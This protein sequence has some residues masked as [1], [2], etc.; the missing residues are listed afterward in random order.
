VWEIPSESASRVG[1]PAPFPVE[2]PARLIHLNT[3]VGDVVLDPFMGS[4]TTAIAALRTGRH[5]L[6][7]EMDPTYVALAEERVALE[8]QRRDESVPITIATQGRSA[9]EIARE[10]IADAGF[11]DIAADRKFREGVDVSFSAR[12]AGGAEFL[13][14]VAGGFTTNYTGLRR[15]DV[16][17]KVLGKA[18]VL[19]AA[20][21][22]LPLVVLSTDLPPKG[23]SGASAL[24][25][26]VGP[27][28]P[29]LDVIDLTAVD[30]ANRLAAYGTTGD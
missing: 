5:Y 7:Y 19:H 29:I 28:Q 3:F 24:A 6:G 4:G 10:F 25:V 12:R 14:E 16:L 20:H 22:E 2:L 18:A 17:W 11:T 8:R 27:D 30:A 23:S 21:P 15:A 13:F 1:H 26:M 9:R